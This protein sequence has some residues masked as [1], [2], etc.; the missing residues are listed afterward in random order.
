[1]LEDI[2][3]TH[4][5]VDCKENF[6][7]LEKA[8]QSWP[9][10]SYANFRPN[11]IRQLL[12][13]KFDLYGKLTS[14]IDDKDLLHG[15]IDGVVPCAYTDVRKLRIIIQM[16]QNQET[17][18]MITKDDDPMPVVSQLP[19][20]DESPLKRTR[21]RLLVV[22]MINLG[23]A[24]IILFAGRQLS[25][26]NNAKRSLQQATVI[27]AMTVFLWNVY[28]LVVTYNC[29][30]NGLL[31]FAYFIV[32]NLVF[33]GILTIVRLVSFGVF[34]FYARQVDQKKSDVVD[35]IICS[36][37]CTIE[38]IILFA[39]KVIMASHAFKLTK[40]LNTN[41]QPIIHTV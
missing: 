33:T 21:S 7:L 36:I 17:K 19:Q 16:Q 18:Y 23:L 1:M 30:P 38:L 27:E 6:E 26:E 12:A 3:Y 14:S 22:I 32:T 34:I 2:S 25:N 31:L 10:Q 39:V 5:N 41:K 11:L 35:L 13:R 4:K 29:K 37:F 40:L 28:G 15:Y 8:A 20:I 24:M 9:L